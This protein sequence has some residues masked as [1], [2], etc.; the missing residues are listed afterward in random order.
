MTT[1]T[2]KTIAVSFDASLGGRRVL[3][4]AARLAQEHDAGL[5]AI[6]TASD[7]ESN[8]AESYARG[9]AIGE[10]M[11]RRGHSIS[12]HLAQAVQ[13]LQLV[14]NRYGVTSDFRVVPESALRDEYVM[15]SFY[16]DLLV[17]GHPDTPGAPSAWS[18]DCTLRRGGIPMLLIPPTWKE[19]V[20][21]RRIV[22]AWNGSHQ[23]RN[24]VKAALPLLI[25]AHVVDLVIIDAEH[26]SGQLGEEP[27]ADV[28]MYLAQN[29]AEIEVHRISSQHR[30]IAEALIEHAV[31]NDADLLVF[32]A[33][34]HAK[35]RET[36]LGGVSRT[37]LGGSTPLPLFVLH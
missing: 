2:M 8:P 14:S 25:R 21:G 30:S 29:G 27:G 12:I 1:T 9:D 19:P 6:C 24:A 17:V 3:D 11:R 15:H 13:T 28:A 18:F 37:L 10:V 4:I 32:G 26:L 5:V 31:G 16:A 36:V 22:V 7:E 23:A 34:S 35:F 33:Y 20:I